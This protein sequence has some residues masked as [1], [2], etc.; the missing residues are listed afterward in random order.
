MRLG[1]ILYFQELKQSSKEG[2]NLCYDFF[3]V[4]TDVELYLNLIDHHEKQFI[5]SF[6]QTIDSPINYNFLLLEKFCN[7]ELLLVFV[8]YEKHFLVIYIVFEI[9]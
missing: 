4:Y 5:D 1:Y 3:D 8:A 9:K 7:S 2:M 6:E